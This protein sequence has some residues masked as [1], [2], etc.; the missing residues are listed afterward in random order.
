M[1]SFG[2]LDFTL[3]QNGIYDLRL[4]V[5]G[6]GKTSTDTVRVALDSQ[7]KV[8]QFAFS[9]QDLIIPVSGMP[10]SV[11]RTYNSLKVNEESGDRHFGPGWSYAIAD[12]QMEIDEEKGISYDESGEAF[13]RRFGGGRNITLTLPGG[14]RS[15][16]V[17]QLVA[18]SGFY[19]YAEW[20]AAPGVH[21]TLEPTCDNRL[22][23]MFSL[24]PYWEAAGPQTPMNAFQFPGFILTMKDGT[25]YHIDREDT[26]GFF[27]YDDWSGAS[28]YI[29]TYGK[30]TLTKVEDC[31]GNTTVFRENRTGI[32]SYNASGQKTKSVV[33]DRDTAGRII[34]VYDPQGLDPDGNPDGPAQ[35]TYEYDDIGNL[36]KVNKLKLEGESPLEPIYQ[37]I[38][39]K[40]DDPDRPH[41]ITSV[42]DPRGITPMRTE[43]DS[44]GRIIATID[45]FG[46]RIDLVHSLSDR[47]E[48]V[49]DRLG[50][51]TI[52]SY[53]ARGNVTATIDAHGNQTTRTYDSL[54]N[55]TSI[56]DP[57]GHT[58]S[59]TYD[60]QGNRTSVTNALGQTTTYDYDQYGNQTAVTDPLGNRTTNTY[61]ANGNLVSSTNALGQ[62]TTQSYDNNGNLTATYDAQGNVTATF[63]YDSEGNLTSTTDPNGITRTFS[64]DANGNQTGTHF[65]WINPTDSTD[66]R[67]VVAQS[68]YNASGQLTETIDPQG[69]RT[70]TEFNEI[71]KPYRTTDRL[72]NTTE[73]TYDARGNVIETRYA[74]DTV[75]RTVYDANGRAFVTMARTVP[76]QDSTGT[77][78]IY[79]ALGRVI[80]SERL[81]NVVIDIIIDNTGGRESSRAA[82]VSADVLSSTSSVY[83]AA[84][85]VIQSTSATGA[86]TRTEYDAAGRQTAVAT[87]TTSEMEDP[88]SEME[89]ESPLEPI[90]R[91][92]YEYD[93]AGRQTLVRDTLGRETTFEYDALGRRVKTTFADGTFTTTTYDQLG[94][95]IAETDQAG[96]TKNFEYDAQGRL[97]AVILPEVVSPEETSAVT[98]GGLAPISASTPTRPR[99]QYEYDQY[100]RLS[101]I[102]DA[103]GRETAFSYDHLGRQLSRT[104]PLG[105]TETQA[106]N[107]L[108]QLAYKTDFKSQ[109]TEFIYDTFGRIQSKRLYG[110]PPSS[111]AYGSPVTPTGNLATDYP[112]T[113]TPD[114]T[115]QFTYDALGRQSTITD[116][117]GITE[118]AYDDLGRVA[119]IVSPEG[120]IH[121][122]YDDT[123]GQ[124]TRT[125]T[126]N[127]D[128]FYDYDQLGRL[129]A[130]SAVKLNG[131]T[132]A[133]PE[134]TTY[135][136]NKIG[137]RDS[138]L[139][140][141]NILTTYQYD[142]LNRLTQL[143][144]QNSADQI[145]AQYTYQLAP[146]GRRTGI[147]EQTRQ[148]DN[149]LAQT[150]ITYTYDQLNR[151]T[152][153]SRRCLAE[154]ASKRNYTTTYTSTSSGTASKK[155]KP[156]T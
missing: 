99:Y 3:V 73:T 81:K 15:T 92:E 40:Y 148:P 76:D 95:R 134:I 61:D 143:T 141:N 86:V 142:D 156:E 114:Q 19:Y 36:S 41:Y 69:N 8:G 57:L 28:S 149:T 16:F 6:G 127:S 64:Y 105:Q 55:E 106:Y 126:A 87:Y 75:T 102:R 74:D 11:I 35:V 79:D 123:T 112:S 38:E 68:I 98:A 78:T 94:R 109:A 45:A 137:S 111:E 83:D 124:H 80:R 62:T 97:T 153:E 5:N 144:H 66:I 130:V 21:A 22:T 140:P 122:E 88:T 89:G 135:S 30:A 63:G 24:E 43:Y 154:A 9:Q 118:Y 117:R 58:T 82:F 132:L 1:T 42:V 150:S 53:D 139:L 107:T 25:Q 7:L 115:I 13:Q 12:I 147:V 145:V 155:Q 91:T 18:G 71:G 34:A 96:A 59:F 33:F 4:T 77:R 108:G 100:G 52:H 131:T 90:S 93:A 29:Q 2:V 17:Y 70:T 103:K 32:D 49:F 60:S 10:L 128:T 133:A 113:G 26:G 152:A 116:A 151:L 121:Y 120:T 136:Y 46:N 67:D 51:P 72:G 138:A 37:T 20:K 23:A 54:N 119:T 104:L 101:T 84:G 125:Y 50:N 31:A 39:Y 14:K 65:Q 27:E 85:R 146:T 56:T 129:I 48:T 44:D 47:T 110:A